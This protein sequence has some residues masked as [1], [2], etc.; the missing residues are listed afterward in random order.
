MSDAAPKAQIG[1]LDSDQDIERLALAASEAIQRLIAERHALRSHAGA[2]ERELMRL[3]AT[4]DELRRQIILI[5][6]SYLTLTTD[7]FKQLQH[8][9]QSIRK[10]I[11]TPTTATGSGAPR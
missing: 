3:R 2:Q 11:Q 5:C 4:N 9:D 8:V 7:F 10:V 1:Q 6:D